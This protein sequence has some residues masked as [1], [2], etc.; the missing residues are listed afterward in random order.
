MNSIV[1]L[2]VSTQIV[3]KVRRQIVNQFNVEISVVREIVNH[4]TVYNNNC[5]L[6]LAHIKEHVD[7]H[8]KEQVNTKL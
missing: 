2:L 1:E 7:N 5:T 4:Q 8:V 6:F 3:S